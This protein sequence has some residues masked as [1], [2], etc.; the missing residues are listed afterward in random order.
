MKYEDSDR[1]TSYEDA[2]AAQ[3]IPT[4]LAQSRQRETD[5]LR[6]PLWV[7]TYCLKV[8]QAMSTPQ[9]LHLRTS[10]GRRLLIRADLLIR[11][12]TPFRTAAYDAAD[13]NIW[14]VFV[15]QSCEPRIALPLGSHE[16]VHLWDNFLH[17]SDEHPE[18]RSIS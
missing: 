15:C 13:S 7:K 17:T 10:H 1:S 5:R 11:R 4:R 2:S 12:H 6:C 8:G 18:R 14:Y 3:M 16:A 9:V